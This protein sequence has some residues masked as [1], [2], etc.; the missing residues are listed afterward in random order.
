M[1]Q[2]VISYLAIGLAYV[3]VRLPSRRKFLSALCSGEL[4]VDLKVGPVTKKKIE[5][6]WEEIMHDLS[7]INSILG[8]QLV[9]CF[10]AILFTL[11][12][13]WDV[14]LWPVSAYRWIR[15]SRTR[16]HWEN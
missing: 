5:N 8:P 6:T 15:I 13:I 16:N 2:F 9:A 12:L 7:T 3:I 14:V 10:L 1:E 4:P 11:R